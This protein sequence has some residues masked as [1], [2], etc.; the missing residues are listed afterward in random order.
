MVNLFT[1]ERIVWRLYGDSVEGDTFYG[2][3]TV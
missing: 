3:I 2:E 1:I